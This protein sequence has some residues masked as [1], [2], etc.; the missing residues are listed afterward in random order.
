VPEPTKPS[1]KDLLTG[2]SKKGIAILVGGGLLAFFV[3][4]LI[5]R[6]L[7]GG[8]GDAASLI[9]VAQDQQEL[10]HLVQNAGQ[11]KSLSAGNENF[12]ATVQLAVGSSQS[13]IIE[14]LQNGGKKLNEKQLNLKVDQTTDDRLAAAS[15]AG[16]YNTTF[17]EIMKSEL[18]QYAQDLQKA[19]QLNKGPNGRALLTDCY[20]QIKLMTIQ[21]ESANK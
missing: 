20:N 11:E 5:L 6:A 7:V 2:G 4:I 3:I 19:Y 12:A 8:G 16:T 13:Q 21:L 18:D 14:F 15:S 10:I 9:V 17:D 1:L